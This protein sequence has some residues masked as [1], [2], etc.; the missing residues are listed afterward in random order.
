[1]EAATS[2]SSPARAQDEFN[3]ETHVYEPHKVGLPPLVPYV[4][5]LWRRRQFALELART[6]LRAQHFST[7]LG[8]LWLV[9]NPLLLS[10]V[11][12]LLV[13]VLR[14][15]SRGA[16]FFAHLMLGLFAFHFISQSL[17]QSA[18]SVTKGGRLVLNT[19]FPRTLLPLSAVMTGFMRFLPTMAVYAVMHVIAGRPFGL[20]LLLAIPVLALITLFCMGVCSLVAALQVYFRDVANF[21]PY[22]N[23]IW[24]YSTPVLYFYSEVPEKLRQFIDLNP[25]TPLFA[26]WSQVIIEGHMPSLKF[27]IWGG[28][29]AIAAFIL[30]SLFFISR[31]RDFAVRL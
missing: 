24:M 2:A 22:F 5:E 26:M 30:G 8:Q 7:V 21:L 18:K 12:F 3:P 23:R 9:I 1:M 11:Y 6:T 25:L 19:A 4:R 13:N 20:H 17:V 14:G 27:W 29:W 31:E 16:V 15:H 10:C 28:A